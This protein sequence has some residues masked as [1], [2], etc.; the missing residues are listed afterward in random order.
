MISIIEGRRGHGKSCF[1]TFLGYKAHIENDATIY[2]NYKLNFDSKRL[3]VQGLDKI[4]NATVIFDEAY[5]FGD[6]R[7]SMSKGNEK[8]NSFAF[9]SRKRDVDLIFVVQ[10]GGVLD[11]RLCDSCMVDYIYRCRAVV[12]ER[13]KFVIK[14][15]DTDKI[16]YVRIYRYDTNYER[17]TK[18]WF[19]PALFF[20]LYNSKEIIDVEQKKL[21]RPKKKKP[22]GRPK[23]SLVEVL[24][25]PS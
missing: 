15:C 7:R 23:K 4:Y 8:L 18:W 16:D 2:A 5:G 21:G 11:K 20:P 3:N 24:K 19:N 25:S 12:K 9:Q 6:R 1:A 22:I 13:G 14:H 17:V 10:L